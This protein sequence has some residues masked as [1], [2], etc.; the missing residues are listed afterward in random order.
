MNA[1][2]VI[3]ATLSAGV[4]IATDGQQIVVAAKEE[5]AATLLQNLRTHKPAVITELEHLQQQWL[6]RV[7]SLL[8]IE[9]KDLLNAEL[10]ARCDPMKHWHTDPALAAKSI[11]DSHPGTLSRLAAT[12]QPTVAPR[13]CPPPRASRP[14]PSPEWLAARNQ[15]IDH[16]M[17]CRACHAPTSRHCATGQTLR[18]QYDNTPES[19]V[20]VTSERRSR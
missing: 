7:A 6:A 13:Q 3:Q 18:E 4:H 9:V 14:Q 12:A 1:S 11:R 2:Q 10:V 17:T 20:V 19:S 8:R 15:Y 5:P 16:L